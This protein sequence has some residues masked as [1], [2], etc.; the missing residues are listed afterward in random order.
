MMYE[1]ILNK[2][3]TYN[4]KK[5]NYLYGWRRC[6]CVINKRIEGN[7]QVLASHFVMLDKI[8]TPDKVCK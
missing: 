8:V 5:S 6:L 3:A 1:K 7:V 4:Y 2:L